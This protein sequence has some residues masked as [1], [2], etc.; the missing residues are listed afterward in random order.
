M[1]PR[2]CS[3]AEQPGPGL[4]RGANEGRRRRLRRLRSDKNRYDESRADL[5]NPDR[6]AMQISS[7]QNVVLSLCIVAMAAVSASA[8]STQTVDTSQQTEAPA[9]AF[10]KPYGYHLE[11]ILRRIKASAKQ[12]SKITLVVKS[13]AP[14]ISPLR[15]EYTKKRRQFLTGIVNG[16]PP[17]QIMAHQGE[18][19]NLYSTIVSQYSCMNLEIRRLLTPG[20]V[21]L[22]EEYRQEQGWVSR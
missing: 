4:R 15:E 8:Q 19:N 1:N 3:G 12:K 14:K 18:L 22:M 16:G 21:K 9:D 10:N 6:Q 11:P 13:Y 17:E 20:Q 5:I 2:P 7:P